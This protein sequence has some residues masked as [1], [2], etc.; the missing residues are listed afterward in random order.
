MPLESLE[1]ETDVGVVPLRFAAE[2]TRLYLLASEPGALWPA[3]VLRNGRAEV[4]IAGERAG[5]TAVL[6]TD[7]E[8][9][10]RILARFRVDAE[11]RRW[12]RDPGPLVV[13]DL[14]G[15]AST[16]DPYGRWIEEE[17]DGA[18]PH[19]AERL[20]GNPV[21][22]RFRARS[23]EL[24]RATFPHPGVLLEVGC[25]TGTETLPMLRA[26]H[27]IL[28]VDISDRM[29]G[30]LRENARREGVEAA[31]TTRRLRAKGL[32]TV[33]RELGP[34][35]LDGAFSTFGALNLEPDLAPV[36]R[37]LRELLRPGG[38][39]VAG[40]FGRVA[41]LESLAS[42]GQ[43]NPRRRFARRHRPAPVGS[44]R[45]PID[46]YFRSPHEIQR[47]FADG[48]KLLH[49]EGLGIVMPPPNFAVRL[50]RLGVRWDP[51]DRWDRRVGMWPVISGWGDQFL[52]V[53]ERSGEP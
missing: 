51:L 28:A 19:Y 53:F 10:D 37:G 44:H 26:G 6:V 1:L 41:V 47:S 33:G 8:T 11:T 20:A 39:F 32:D 36:A 29:L 50:E 30:E 25:G 16:V 13:V 12:F 17:F 5:G 15:T 48:F 31:L 40:V 23:L 2:S 38:R 21:E 49:V 14:G 9:R 24:L 22:R 35:S 34:A 7:P 42:L 43:G 45:F 3:W 4:R 46:V 27:R 18:A 52:A